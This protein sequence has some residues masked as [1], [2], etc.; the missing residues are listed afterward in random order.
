MKSFYLTL[1][2]AASKNYKNTAS[3]FINDL[4]E[5]L[6]LDSNIEF[7]L[8]EV[9]YVRRL[10]NFEYEAES[11]KIFDYGEGDGGVLLSCELI[12]V[13]FSN[14]ELCGYV[15]S[16]IWDKVPRLKNVEIFSY[17]ASIRRYRIDLEKTS[18]SLVL[19]K[20]LA[21]TFGVEENFNQY[22][23]NQSKH[24]TIDR[25]IDH[26]ISVS[27]LQA[28]M[29]DKNFDGFVPIQG[30]IQNY[31]SKLNMGQSIFLY[32]DLVLDQLTGDSF[33]NLLRRQ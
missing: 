25:P 17:V 16:V 13:F 11:L 32:C 31:D 20:S 30:G 3:K 8:S 12:D 18:I 2:S 15:N 19:K 26:I 5:I 29:R 33:S 22:D 7:G 27:F 14:E 21:Y 6:R 24:F 9:S 10:N 23:F 28:V 4:P 1:I